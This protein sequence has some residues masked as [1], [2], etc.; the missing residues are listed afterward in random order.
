[1]RRSPT[2]RLNASPSTRLA[3]RPSK[4]AKSPSSTPTN[5]LDAPSRPKGRKNSSKLV[6]RDEVADHYAARGSILLYQHFARE[7]R[8][9]FL[10]RI[11]ANLSESLPA[12]TI[13]SFP[14]ANVVFFLA[15]SREHA[16]SLADV[17]SE[18]S[19]KWPAWFMRSQAHGLSGAAA[20]EMT[21]PSS[22]G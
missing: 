19:T 12:A 5:G 16:Q 9:T 20:P 11:A 4:D 3:S 18:I 13:W 22:S 10:T 2:R 1:M 17:V 14:T 6:Y 7:H 15:A 8:P 21:S